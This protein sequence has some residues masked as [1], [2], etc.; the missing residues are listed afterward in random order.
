M[1]NNIKIVPPQPCTNGIH[2]RFT[3]IWNQTDMI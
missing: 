2:D 1:G 3:T